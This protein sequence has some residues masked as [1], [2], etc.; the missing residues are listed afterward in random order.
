MRDERSDWNVFMSPQS[1][2]NPSPSNI[3]LVWAQGRTHDNTTYHCMAL[4][5]LLVATLVVSSCF[6][7]FL[8]GHLSSI[9]CSMSLLIR[10]PLRK[11]SN[12]VPCVRLPA[13][14]G[15][16]ICCL[17]VR[18]N[19]SSG[20]VALQKNRISGSY[21]NNHRYFSFSFPCMTVV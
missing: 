15:K 7:D 6:A 4:L 14:Y 20:G 16:H 10:K 13:A 8:P 17:R 5:P 18:L 1:S 2:A 19:G 3:C 21:L 11:L 12:Y 9:S